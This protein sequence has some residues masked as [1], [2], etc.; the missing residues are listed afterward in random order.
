MFELSKN[1]LIMK[2]HKF[3]AFLLLAL[4]LVAVLY[5]SCNKDDDEDIRLIELFS[6]GPSPV[7]RGGELRFIGR[8]LD[9]VTAVLL[10]DNVEVTS[11]KTK[12]SELLTIDVPEA[13]VTG[14]VVLKTPEG[15]IET[16]TLLAISEPI[17]ITAVS[18]AKVRPGDV[19]TITGDYLNLVK[20]VIFTN[21]KSVTQFASQS[22]TKLE[23]AVP[24]DAQS[25]KVVVSNGEADPILVESEA[26]LEVSLPVVNKLSPSPVKAGNL[27][28]IEGTDL[29]LVTA[30]TFP[31]GIKV[32][33]WTTV[34]AGKLEAQVPDNAQDGKLRLGVASLLEVES[35]AELLML[36]PGLSAISPNPAKNGKTVTVTGTDL[37][38]VTS[39]VF[40]GNK[41][42]NV[43]E[44]SSAQLTVEV[45]VDALE[46]VLT[47][48]TA[49]NKSVTSTSVLQ[50]VKPVITAIS[51]T[52]VKTNETITIT[53]QNLDLVSAVVFGGDKTGT[54]TGATETELMI[55]V[56]SASQTCQLTLH[57]LN[58]SMVV[59]QSS[60][61]ILP[62]NVPVV[63]AIPTVA[64][65][66]QM[67]TIEGE[68]MDLVA[69]VVFPGEIKATRYGAKTATY[70]EVVVPDDV[71]KGIGTLRL[72]TF[73]NEFTVTPAI[74]IQGVDQVEDT[75][76]LFFDFNGNGLDSWW[77]DAGG[78][79]NDPA[80][81]VDGSN[82]FRVNENRNGW[83]GLF[84]RNGQNNFPAATIGT[85]VDDYA[86]K[87]DINVLEPITGGS[88]KLRLKGSEGDFWYIWG[89]AGL[90]GQTIANTNGWITLTIPISALKD[91]YGW[92][93]ISIQD[94]NSINED[95]GMAFDSGASKVNI[96]IDNI[97]FAKIR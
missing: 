41:P 61:T 48:Q 96:A 71:D 42:G 33:A 57:T 83:S 65:P 2:I 5:T 75:S 70:L 85:N 18:P 32:E 92:G 37:D 47:L 7:L 51:P 63:T 28:T 3:K 55:V 67:I 6:F 35:N 31:G 91:N 9:Q 16:K 62:S 69:E 95:F 36:V 93:N 25:G 49:A 66:G 56:P 58:G 76:L 29:D 19:V 89:P 53:G 77:G 21:K 24:L 43:L 82:Y 54:I 73:E 26:E 40:S 11:F 79:E 20:E 45:P 50:L 78:V 4:G 88:L 10:S 68:K 30:L 12:T 13:T 15:D 97:R 38:L 86:V 39:V 81:S 80:I 87:L 23:V 8:N 17:S 1:D 90:D 14:K 94:L 46:G 59:S 27:L 74:N 84:W 22:R 64:K 60:L 72:V 44:Q 34:D 52:S